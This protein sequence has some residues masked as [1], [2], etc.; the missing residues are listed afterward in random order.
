MHEKIIER[1][2]GDTYPIAIT[3]T[4]GGQPQNIKGYAMTMSVSAVED[5]ETADYLFQSVANIDSGVDGKA[6]FPVTPA[7]VD[8]IGT[9]YF[10]IEIID[11]GGF[12]RTPVKGQIIFEQ[13]ITKDPV[14]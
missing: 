12:K 14:P 4:R 7:D 2:R 13:D 3:C 8:R 1:F 5:P 10:D 11:T 6:H 9:V